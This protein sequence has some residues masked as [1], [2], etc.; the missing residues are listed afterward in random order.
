MAGQCNAR[1]RARAFP[2]P[3]HKCLEFGRV[4]YFEPGDKVSRCRLDLL[5][6]YGGSGGEPDCHAGQQYQWKFMFDIFDIHERS[7]PRSGCKPTK[8]TWVC[9]HVMPA[10]TIALLGADLS[11]PPDDE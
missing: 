8:R 5:R 10:S 11:L 4:G 9:F 2:E 1:R 6:V 7:P 3:A